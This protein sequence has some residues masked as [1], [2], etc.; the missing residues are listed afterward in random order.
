MTLKCEVSGR[1][2][3]AP[4]RSIIETTA[5]AVDTL[6][7]SGIGRGDLPQEQYSARSRVAPNFIWEVGVGHPLLDQV[8]KLR[9]DVWM[10][11]GASS[12]HF[13]GGV[14]TDDHD[15]V[16]CR[17]WV[18]LDEANKVAGA[19]R[20]CIHESVREFPERHLFEGAPLDL[21]SPIGL[22]SRLVVR[23][24]FRGR[25]LAKQFDRARI[26]ASRA[27]GCAALL[28]GV[29]NWSSPTRLAALGALG[30]ELLAGMRNIPVWDERVDVVC[31]D[32]RESS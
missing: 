12:D 26:Q 25:G 5:G 18:A 11:L 13:P 9:A 29:S 19:A 2:Q 8:F 24:G 28:V 30:F 1:D 20:L 6:W 32:L 7:Q 31:L 22:L 17:H 4:M 15:L 21:P 16:C 10:A 3:G 23:P 27:A 14:W